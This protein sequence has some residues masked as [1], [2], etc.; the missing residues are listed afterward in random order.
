MNDSMSADG[1]PRTVAVGSYDRHAPFF[2]ATVPL[3]GGY[4]QP[5]E[6]GQTIGGRDGTDRHERMLL[7]HEFAAA[8]VSLASYL[9]AKDRGSPLV[10]VPVFPRR[11]CSMTQVWVRRDSPLHSA[12][13]LAGTRIGIN[14]FQTTL[15]VLF[16]ADLKDHYGVS[17]GGI[18]WV[19]AAPEPLAFP[20]LPDLSVTLVDGGE[21]LVDLLESGEI[22]AVVHPHPPARLTDDESTFRRLVADPVME[23]QDYVRRVGFFPVMHVLAMQPSLLEAVPGADRTLTDDFEAALDVTWDRWR[24]PNWSVCGVYVDTG[25]QKQLWRNG[26]EVNRTNL[27]WFAESMRDQGLVSEGFDVDYVWTAVSTAS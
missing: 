3:L 26:H 4:L 23:E 24:D 14:T 17:T 25:R 16:R 9:I 22:E 21:A 18:R 6:V 8:E 7:D 15:S 20:S 5:L 13:D 2:D 10:A 11:L 1:V 19:T 27:R 12:Q